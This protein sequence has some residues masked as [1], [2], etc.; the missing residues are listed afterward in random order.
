MDYLF[1]YMLF[2]TTR[3]DINPALGMDSYIALLDALEKGYGVVGKEE[4]YFVCESL[5]I[6]N[7]KDQTVFRQTF[8]QYSKLILRE[9]QAQKEIEE[10]KSEVKRSTK[11][12][13]DEE[14]VDDLEEITSDTPKEKQVNK[15][16]RIKEQDKGNL[17]TCANIRWENT[18]PI[19]ATNINEPLSPVR[20]AWQG[21]F[22]MSDEAYQ[23]VSTWQLQRGW[24]NLKVKSISQR[25]DNM[26]IPR[27]VRHMA[28]QGVLT[29]VFYHK[30]AAERQPNALQLVL[31][32]DF[33]GSMIAFRSFADRL[34][35]SVGRGIKASRV[36]FFR[37]TPFE[38][39]YTQ[40]NWTHAVATKDLVLQC[41]PRETNVLIFSDAG[42]ARGNFSAERMQHTWQFLDELNPKTKNIIWLNPMPQ[43]RWEGSTAEY[44]ARLTTMLE[45]DRFGIEKALMILK[46]YNNELNKIN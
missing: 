5:W 15:N 14:D 45:A 39:F 29:D 35:E 20:I 23:P 27:T 12:K 2:D 18:L 40:P 32:V 11:A 38:T 1:L 41:S 7:R 22:K 6:Q 8:E 46:G 42:A 3:K 34:A 44:I 16:D 13:N 25:T 31:L 9:I 30:S 10:H 19:S 21:R 33:K 37:N 36:L 17:V 43:D 28:K 24:H 26:D 4:L